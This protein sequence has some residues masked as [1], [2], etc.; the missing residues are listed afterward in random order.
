MSFT[1]LALCMLSDLGGNVV[2]YI[3]SYFPIGGHRRAGSRG[4]VNM[5]GGGGGTQDFF[6]K[7][8][9]ESCERENFLW[10]EIMFMLTDAFLERIL[11]NNTC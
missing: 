10:R 5:G 7:R 2:H 6:L 3:L 11:Q 1:C 4:F 8:T 9:S